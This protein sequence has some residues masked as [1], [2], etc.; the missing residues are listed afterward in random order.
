MKHYLTRANDGFGFGLMDQVFD[1]FFN[2]GFNHTP[3]AMRTDLRET[4]KGYEL[5]IDLPGFDKKDINLS[6]ED[7]YLTISASSENNENQEGYIRRER[8]YSCKRS[9][10]VGKAVT[11]QD[12][13]AKYENGILKIDIP[14]KEQK[15][16]PKRNIQID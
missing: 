3:K 6:L 4:D 8:I 1:D 10:F 12:V 9:Y 13:K 2:M 7:G 15:E 14:K 11:E 5:S 16:L